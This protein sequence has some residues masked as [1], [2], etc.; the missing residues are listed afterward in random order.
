MSYAYFYAWI[1]IW[2]KSYLYLS[3]SSS[4]KY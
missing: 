4:L 1:A 3:K 2:T